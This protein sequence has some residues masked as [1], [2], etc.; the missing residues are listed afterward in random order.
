MRSACCGWRCRATRVRAACWCSRKR[1]RRIPTSPARSSSGWANAKTSTSPMHCGCGCAAARCSRRASSTSTPLNPTISRCGPTWRCPRSPATASP[2]GPA[3]SL[4]TTSPRPPPAHGCCGF[5]PPEETTMAAFAPLF[6]VSTVRLQ[7]E[8]LI[9]LPDRYR[10]Q[11]APTRIA[12]YESTTLWLMELRAASAGSFDLRWPA[13]GTA[14][15]VDISPS[16]SAALGVDALIEFSVLPFSIATTLRA[17]P[18]GAP[19]FYLG[20]TGTP[21]DDNAL[22]Q[23]GDPPRSVAQLWLGVVFQDRQVRASWAW[24]DAIGD[25]LA[26]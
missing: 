17:L 21:P 9:T 16:D 25:A 15:V 23:P 13:A 12:R 6:D 20:A 22:L 18:G 19:T 1:W 11:P 5:R 24:V 10:S 7:S 3:L 2:C 26:A 14:R 4:T 8:R